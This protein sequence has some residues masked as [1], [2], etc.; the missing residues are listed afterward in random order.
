ME[1]L[2]VATGGLAIAGVGAYL[3]SRFRRDQEEAR[4]RTAAVEGDTKFGARH[5]GSYP[6]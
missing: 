3:V 4:R 1:R 2:G 6:S 5:F